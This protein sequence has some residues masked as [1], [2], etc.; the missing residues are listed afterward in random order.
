VHILG[1]AQ[2]DLGHVAVARDPPGDTDEVPGGI[3][4]AREKID[5]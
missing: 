4:R 1:I 5:R 2:R 3:K